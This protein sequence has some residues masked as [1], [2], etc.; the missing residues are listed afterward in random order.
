[1]YQ[2]LS[3]QP[4]GE[5]VWDELPPNTKSSGNKAS[6]TFILC[7]IWTDKGICALV[8]IQNPMVFRSGQMGI[9]RNVSL[10]DGYDDD[11]ADF[12][13]SCAG[14]TSLCSSFLKQSFSHGS[15]SQ[16]VLMPQAEEAPE[17]CMCFVHHHCSPRSYRPNTEIVPK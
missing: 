12:L 4:H 6:Q 17:H 15:H 11:S 2:E 3:K 14:Q 7:R 8:Q 16:A 13:L 5:R 1:M 10:Q 9:V